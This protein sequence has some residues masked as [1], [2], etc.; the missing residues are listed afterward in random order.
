M[1]KIPVSLPAAVLCGALLLSSCGNDNNGLG[2]TFNTVI[3]ANPE[4]LDPQ[5]AEDSASL[6]IIANI[7]EGLVSIGADGSPKCAAAE[8]YSVSDDG[9]TYT[10][11]LR[12]GICWNSISGFSAKLTA[13][14]FVYAFKRIFDPDM[15]SPYA[16]EFSCIKHSREVYSG[17]M[18]PADLGVYAEDE[19]TVVFTLEYPVNEFLYMLTESAAMP[20]NEEFFLSTEGRYGLDARFCAGNGAFTLTEWNFDPY[21]TE[22]HLQLRKISANS[23]EGHITCPNNVNFIIADSVKDYERA[24][25][26]S[27][28]CQIYTAA[29][30]PVLR[31]KNLQEYQVSSAGLTFNP[32]DPRLSDDNMRFALAAASSPVIFEDKT[33]EGVRPSRSIFPPAVT[34][35][36][37]S[38]S[39][40]AGMGEALFPP[41]KAEEWFLRGNEAR[42][43]GDLLSIIVPDTF[44][45]APLMYMLTDRWAELTGIECGIESLSESDYEKRISEGDYT[46]ALT[47]ISCG[48][49]SPSA[50][51]DCY[52][53]YIYSRE[54]MLEAR[55]YAAAA[56]SSLSAETALECCGYA[57]K[58]IL[59]GAYYIPLFTQ[60]S[61][62]VTNDKTEDIRCDPFSGCINFKD[63]KKYS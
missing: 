8:S 37:R 28:D 6:N 21:W 54:Q 11:R 10:F 32:D 3:T 30:L 20:C 17:T 62:L 41:E 31:N 63:A 16:S 58:S 27:S 40:A 47:L 7:F 53:P 26:Q 60:S 34:V 43:D 23:F 61:F 29:E 9:L 12:D 35:M 14:D 36:G 59:S 24:S 19:L 22:N 49:N 42:A 1:K 13:D 56:K 15:M 25:G 52:A 51:T 50:F 39:S 38:V 2:G 5:T 4:N 57:E 55:S 18:S 44:A 46:I 48:R 33:S 45:D